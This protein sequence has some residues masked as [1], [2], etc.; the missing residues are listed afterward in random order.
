LKKLRNNKDCTP[1]MKQYVGIDVANGHIDVVVMTITED[2]PVKSSPSKRISM[3]VA[4]LKQLVKLTQQCTLVVIEATG[5]YERPAVEALLTAGIAVSCINPRTSRDFAKSMNRLAK[6]DAIDAKVLAEMGFRLGDTLR[7]TQP[8]SPVQT[9]LKALS[10]TRQTFVQQA[11]QI[12]NRLKQSTGDSHAHYAR[13]LKDCE[14]HI[15]RVDADLARISKALP[16]AKLLQSVCGVGKVLTHTLLGEFPEL[17]KLDRQAVAALAGLAPMN[18]DSGQ[19]R[20][21]R[22]II[23]GRSEIRDALYMSA[24]SAIKHN[25]VIKTFYDRLIASGKAFKVAI[26]ACMR[27]LLVILNAKMRDFLAA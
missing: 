22:R 26:T 27:K 15:A 25:P 19:M 17:G 14:S 13:A 11:T 8:V 1:K 20:G 24:L 9:Q 12:K 10:R 2:K 5:G 18:C 21:K 6:T 23:G 7:K 4:G 3:T 16:E